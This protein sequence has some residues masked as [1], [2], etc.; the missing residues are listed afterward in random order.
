MKHE[1]LLLH[2]KEKMENSNSYEYSR[3][4]MKDVSLKELRDRLAEFAR[5]RGWDQ[6]HS[7]RNLLLALVSLLTCLKKPVDKFIMSVILLYVYI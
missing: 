1:L 6:Y 7:P 2:N 5:V 3:K 4:V